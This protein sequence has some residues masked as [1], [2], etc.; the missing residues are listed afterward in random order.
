MRTSVDDSLAKELAAVSE[1]EN[2]NAK[3]RYRLNQKLLKYADKSRMPVDEATVRDLLRN[4][5]N[6]R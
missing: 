3:N 1:E 5:H 2:F 6:F 4:Q